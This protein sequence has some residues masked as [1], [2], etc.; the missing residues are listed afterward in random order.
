MRTRAQVSFAFE[1]CMAVSIEQLC[2]H[3]HKDERIKTEHYNVRIKDKSAAS[4][5]EGRTFFGGVLTITM[6]VW[7]ADQHEVCALCMF[8]LRAGSFTLTCMN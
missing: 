7:G 6:D 3:L 1:N 8:S 5:G 4:N 2:N